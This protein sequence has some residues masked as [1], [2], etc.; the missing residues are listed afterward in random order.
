[1][2]LKS[3]VI[4]GF[5]SFKDRTVIQ[6]DQGITGIVGPNGC[7]KSNIVDA[8]FWVMGEQSAKHLRGHTMR[9]VI[10]SGSSKYGP[11]SYAEAI[12][13]LTNDEQKHI[14]IGD[15]VLSPLEIQVSRRLYRN[16][17]SD[18]RIND[19]PARLKDV[20]EIFMDTGA[21][22]K[23]YSIIA[24]GEISKIIQ[25]KPFERRS[26][27]E[28][29]AGI[30]KFKLKKKESQKKM[31]LTQQ[32][33]QRL[34]DLKGEVQ[35][36]LKEL[37]VQSEK[38][39]KA[40]GFKEKLKKMDIQ[41][42]VVKEKSY[43][44][45]IKECV[46]DLH[47][48]KEECEKLKHEK[49]LLDNQV[50]IEKIEKTDVL[51]RVDSEQKE[52][53]QCSTVL[54]SLEERKKYLISNLKEK[55]QQHDNVIKH[56]LLLE[57]EIS[58]QEKKEQELKNKWDSFQCLNEEHHLSSDD[59][60]DY[61]EKIL[62]EI[63]DK[64]KKL[65]LS[66]QEVF[67]LYQLKNN[68]D[69]DLFKNDRDLLEL[70]KKI[71][72]L[73]STLFIKEK[74]DIHLK[75]QQ[76][77]VDQLNKEIEQN[78]LHIQHQ[79][80]QLELKK[81]QIKIEE[82]ERQALQEQKKS[83][84]SYLQ[85]KIEA[86]TSMEK[87]RSEEKKRWNSQLYE[88]N[89]CEHI[90]DMIECDSQYYGA[91]EM[92]FNKIKQ[93][94]FLI[95]DEVSDELILDNRNEE[96]K[97]ERQCF[98]VTSS[99]FDENIIPLEESSLIWFE[100]IVKLKESY[101]TEKGLDE[102]LRSICKRHVICNEF[103]LSTITTLVKKEGHH[104]DVIVDQKG[105]KALLRVGEGWFFIRGPEHSLE[106]MGE[107]SGH[108]FL[109]QCEQ[110]KNTL[111]EDLRLIDLKRSEYRQTLK[112]LETQLHQNQ[113]DSFS[114]MQQQ[115]KNQTETQVVLKQKERLPQ[116][117]KDLRDQLSLISQERLFLMENE[118]KCKK[119]LSD[120]S[121]QIRDKKNDQYSLEQDTEM[122]EQQFQE[123]REEKI[124]KEADRKN[125][126]IQKKQIGEQYETLKSWMLKEKKRFESMQV[127]KVELNEK[128]LL[129]KNEQ[130]K[131][132][133]DITFKIDEIKV[134]ESSLAQQKNYLATLATKIDK[135]ESQLHKLQQKII[136][137]EKEMMT[138]QMRWENLRDEEYTWVRNYA[139]TYFIAL[140]ELI[141][142]ADQWTDDGEILKPFIFEEDHRR[143]FIQLPEHLPQEQELVTKIKQLKHSLD[144][145]GEIN[146]ASLEAYQHQKERFDF[147]KEQEEQLN[148][149]MQ[150]LESA[151]KKIDE[152]SQ[153][154][155]QE[156]FHDVNQYFERV[157]PL[158]FGGGQARLE[159]LKSESEADSG[160]DILAC[161][162][163]KKMQNI[164]LMSG[165]EKAM[166]A[167]S[168]IFSI[169]L[170]R[171]S[172][173][174]LLDEVDAPLD[175]ANV[176]RFNTLLREMSERSQ[177]IL[178]THNKKTMELNNTL[179]GVT[180]QEP[181][182]SKALSIQLQ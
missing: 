103:S 5:K 80:D 119:S 53:Y 102:K 64:K 158:L 27:I 50:Q 132:E 35:K 72:E 163:G 46:R 22:A 65:S 141:K 15:K 74:E 71:E 177:F 6:F 68:L 176:T 145:L 41:L 37:E 107:L 67:N 48:K 17:E 146:W 86:A 2:K 114:L 101:R 25:A 172:P 108:Q 123:K 154:R 33:L 23:S 93:G 60:D 29:V 150:D 45:Q 20:Q 148:T 151:I 106:E 142:N 3:L 69:K 52:F 98:Y 137:L 134:K 78:N 155:F 42:G 111:I 58:A 138:K 96:N 44:K 164:N 170:V 143:E 182:V 135:Q 105:E 89:E 81:N 8:L 160:I 38:A 161:P 26:M 165:G 12:L 157:F 9:D 147:L 7:G 75:E 36:H 181:G 166:T 175:D 118:E 180:M 173:F 57:K 140:R 61:A 179:Y 47:E 167:V 162:P 79:K 110:E 92:A 131:I 159:L 91:V 113:K 4:Q 169:F 122:L 40:K 32:N 152:K 153:L 136:H 97:Q 14:H 55:S 115:I 149:S 100:S 124:Q 18:Y 88:K 1:V 121:V 63:Q 62:D 139:E 21:G 59:E 39:Q 144:E 66:K 85:A 117:T 77:K 95:G 49:N 90:F 129:L 156:A 87:H 70:A 116:Q 83:D 30:T 94:V 10:F 13:I 34:H 56:I 120:I 54:S 84:L 16:G 31:E 133:T 99:S 125:F 24:Q 19:I 171:P 127:E 178:I 43:L 126:V 82:E 104:I 51:Q 168:L 112:E 174:C 28:D 76:E 128:I 73:T 130:E 11:S 109:Q